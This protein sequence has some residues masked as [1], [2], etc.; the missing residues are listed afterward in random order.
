[1]CRKLTARLRGGKVGK[2]IEFKTKEQLE[3][4][5]KRKKAMTEIRKRAE[6]LDWWK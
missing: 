3:E 4:E 2:V 6:K 1:M 5:R